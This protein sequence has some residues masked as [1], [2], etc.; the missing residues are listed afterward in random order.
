MKVMIYSN[1]HKMWW[2]PNYCGYTRHQELAGV[3]DYEEAHKK[4]PEIDFNTAGEDFF[5]VISKID[6][7]E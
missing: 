7:E 4:Y 5:V 6:I 1:E 3:F 2:K